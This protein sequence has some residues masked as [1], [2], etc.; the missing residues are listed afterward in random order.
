MGLE[1]LMPKR[2]VHRKNNKKSKHKCP[3]CNI[4]L[5]EGPNNLYCTG[6]SYIK[7]R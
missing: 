5:T 1:K 4:R 6:C 7:R 2:K 3:E